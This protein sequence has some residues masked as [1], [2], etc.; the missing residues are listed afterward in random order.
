MRIY[1]SS[2]GSV[3]TWGQIILSWRGHPGRCGGLSPIPGLHPLHASG[4]LPQ[5]SQPEM[6]PGFGRC[7]VANSPVCDSGCDG[8][9]PLK[10]PCLES[11]HLA[12]GSGMP[13][14]CQHPHLAFG[15]SLPLPAACPESQCLRDVALQPSGS[16][17]RSGGSR[18]VSGPRTALNPRVPGPALF[19]RSGP[20]TEQGALLL[21]RRCTRARACVCVCLLCRFQAVGRR[22]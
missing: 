19:K 20:K 9:S 2:L 17:P 4:S 11:V 21:R 13:R 16:D 8:L 7:L 1:W 6:S 14:S 18:C 22:Q 12:G 3:D 5:S 15:H 10:T